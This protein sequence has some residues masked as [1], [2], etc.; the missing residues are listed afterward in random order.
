MPNLRRALD[1]FPLVAAML[2]AS[3]PAESSP[4]LRVPAGTA[5]PVR[6]QTT[7]SSATSHPEDRVDAAV[8][9]DV[10]VGG[11]VVIPAGSELRGH[12]VTAR[13]SGRVKGRAYLAVQFDRLVVRGRTYDIATRR[14]AVLAPATKGRDAKTIGG[15]AGAGAIIGAIA[16]GK[17]GA[18]KGALIGGAAGTGVVLATRGKEVTLPAGSRWRVRLDRPLVIE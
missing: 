12:V 1:S 14:L 7:V 3:A 2:L 13:R 5:I 18:A 16:D 15:G 6:F 4:S 11:A 10:R 8:R 17:E 9:Q